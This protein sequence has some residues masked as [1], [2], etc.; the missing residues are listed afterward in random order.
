[1]E[2]GE[3]SYYM[4][5]SRFSIGQTASLKKA[6]SEKEVLDYCA[7]IDDHNPIHSDKAYAA[8]TKFKQCIVPGAMLASLFSRILGSTMPGNG[9]IY[10][11]Q[12]SKFLAPVLIGETVEVI[13]SISAIRADK[14]IITCSTRIVKED[15]VAAIEGEA[16]VM[17]TEEQP[18]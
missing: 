6:F 12:N 3:I 11:G 5:D 9:T 15:G 18:R 16:V 4:R 13:V 17:V 2:F 8:T 10:L 14:P 7:L 1:M